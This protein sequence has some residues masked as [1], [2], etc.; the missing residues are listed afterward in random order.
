[1]PD[2][3]LDLRPLP[4]AGRR[5]AAF[6][7]YDELAVGESLVLVSDDDAGRLRAEFDAEYGGGYGWD[8]LGRSPTACRIRITRHASTAL[9]RVLGDAAALGAAGGVPGEAG[10]VWKLQMLRRDL[11]SNIVA[12]P[13]GEG[14]GAHAGPDLDVLLVVLGGSGRIGT[15]LG[16]LDLHPGALVW[17]PRRSRREFTA[18]PGGLRYLTV[19]QRRQSLTIG[20]PPGDRPS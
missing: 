14:I 17:L 19:H 10:A 7:A 3:E 5:P 2:P 12:L 6:H 11:D 8:I 15:E 9:P 16:A 18:G 20:R 4:D 1:M 13:P